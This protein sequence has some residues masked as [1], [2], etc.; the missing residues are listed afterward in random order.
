[1][2][3]WHVE[4]TASAN[5]DVSVTMG[6]YSSVEQTAIGLPMGATVNGCTVTFHYD[7][8][9]SFDAAIDPAAPEFTDEWGDFTGYRL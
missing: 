7:E 6:S 1:M 3:R 4:I 2:D 9:N 8:G 5:E